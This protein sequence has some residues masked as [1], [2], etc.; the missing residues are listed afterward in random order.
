MSDV[1]FKRKSLMCRD[2]IGSWENVIMTKEEARI[3]F[4][5]W[6]DY[7][8]IADKFDRLMLPIPESFLPYPADTLEEAL[9]IIAKD[10]FDSGNMKMAE[11]IQT[12]MA[13]YLSPFFF[14]GTEGF[15]KDE[16]AIT[17]MKKMLDMME[18][19]PDLKKTLLNNLKECQDSWIKLR[20][21]KNN[22]T[23]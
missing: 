22:I 5:S 12:T 3:I 16:E 8:E 18:E 1:D 9:N 14:K 13:S 19:N 23:N 21:K 7:M 4:K 15:T 17:M 6:Q 20:S 10:F 2:F 11:T